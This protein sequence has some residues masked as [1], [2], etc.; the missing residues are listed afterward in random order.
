MSRFPLLLGLL[1]LVGV[2]ANPQP[3]AAHH[4]PGHGA[5]EGVRNINSLGGT[6]GKALS[7][8]LILNETYY[9]GQGLNPGVNESLSVF[10]EYAPVPAFS[11]GVQLP[12]AVAAF[13][14]DDYRPRAGLGDM[15][16]AFRFT[17]HASKLIHR[18][19]TTG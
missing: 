11:L 7:R 19:F 2:V 14:D 1:A 16:L 10:G 9:T 4:T 13:A 18:V 12:F 6:G 3:A 8:L 15:R 5:S 17:P